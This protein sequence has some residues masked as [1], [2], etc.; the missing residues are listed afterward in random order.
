MAEGDAVAEEAV[1]EDRV[2]EKKYKFRTLKDFMMAQFEEM[3]EKLVTAAAETSKYRA[4]STKK[5]GQFD[6][7]INVEYEKNFRAMNK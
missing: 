7:K 4:T 1:V 3:K 6:H 5:M 2:V